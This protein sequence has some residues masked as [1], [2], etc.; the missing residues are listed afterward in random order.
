MSIVI[1]P[2]TAMAS[3]SIGIHPNSSDWSQQCGVLLISYEWRIT[4]RRI[5]QERTGSIRTPRPTSSRCW[6]I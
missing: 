3:G 5:T 4:A 1:A 6:R 2:F